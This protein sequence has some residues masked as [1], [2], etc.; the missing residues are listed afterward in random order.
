LSFINNEQFV[1][2]L[3]F[4]Y[5][6]TPIN[7]PIIVKIIMKTYLILSLI[8]LI[9]A[10]QDIPKD[11]NK[12][13]EK[14]IDSYQRGN[15]K[16][17]EELAKEHNYNYPGLDTLIS[18]FKEKLNNQEVEKLRS[19]SLYTDYFFTGIKQTSEENINK[20]KKESMIN[21]LI[22]ALGDFSKLFDK[23]FN[24]SPEYEDKIRTELMEQDYQHITQ[25]TKEFGEAM[26]GKKYMEELEKHEIIQ[27]IL[28]KI[29]E[30]RDK[31]ESFLKEKIY[32]KQDE[33][34]KNEMV[35]LA[36]KEF[37]LDMEVQKYIETMDREKLTTMAIHLEKYHRKELGQGH[38]LGGIHDY[39]FRLTEEEIRNY[40]MKEI[41]EHPDLNNVK[42]LHSLNN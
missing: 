35:F 37:E 21:F 13:Q 40:I 25:L 27:Y 9:A 26:L 15:C 6:I 10:T 38:V 2:Y 32:K 19:I 31:L 5:T 3:V 4:Y 29:T 41:K 42:K 36:D 20:A 30:N 33:L 11:F 12:F 7:I 8:F 39:I 17:L 34:N 18:I 16:F 1:I 23:K 24:T 28:K 22:K 14:T